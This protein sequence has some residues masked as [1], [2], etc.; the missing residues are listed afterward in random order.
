[1]SQ[2]EEE[3]GFHQERSP[4]CSEGI[5]GPREELMWETP[6]ID[7]L[8]HFMDSLVPFKCM[9]LTRGAAAQRFFPWTPLGSPRGNIS[10]TAS[11]LRSPTK[12]GNDSGARQAGAASLITGPLP[13]IHA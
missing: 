6:F 7:S 1:M 4:S 12:V 9:R 8:I 13:K 5:A 3:P 11:S 2:W 10:Y